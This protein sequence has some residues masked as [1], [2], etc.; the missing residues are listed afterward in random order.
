[1]LA[2]SAMCGALKWHVPPHQPNQTT[3]KHVGMLVICPSHANPNAPPPGVCANFPVY[4]MSKVALGYYPLHH[5]IVVVYNAG[6]LPS[7]T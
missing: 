3:S 1:M 5:V 6:I 4:H 7:C 2:T